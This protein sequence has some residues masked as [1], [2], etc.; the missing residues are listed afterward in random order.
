MSKAINERYDFKQVHDFVPARLISRWTRQILDDAENWKPRKSYYTYGRLYYSDIQSDNIG[1]YHG[2]APKDNA[3]LDKL[4]SMR[5]YVLEAAKHLP[6]L[7]LLN[8]GKP[9]VL[10]RRETT[11]TSCWC[12]YGIHIYTPLQNSSVGAHVDF[13]LFAPYPEKML[14]RDTICYSMTLA[15]ACPASGGGLII[16]PRQKVWANMTPEQWPEALWEDKQELGYSPGT[17][18]LFNSFCM[19]QVEPC[20]ISRKAPWRITLLTHFLYRPELGCWEY[21][22]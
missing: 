14:N 4:P 13:E 6:S 8:G 11:K 12:D 21:W 20:Q 5:A 16:W 3:L 18:S 10:S 17:L 22:S 7:A 2:D 19:H 1:A 15:I 9:R